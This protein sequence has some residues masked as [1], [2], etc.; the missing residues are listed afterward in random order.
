MGFSSLSLKDKTLFTL[1]AI[2]LLF[3]A[4]SEAFKNFSA[5]LLIGFFL[6]SVVSGG[7]KITKDIINIS[8]ISHLAIVLIGILVG[9]NTNESLGQVMDV[10]HIVILFLFFREANLHF[11]SYERILHFLFIGFI[12]AA[13]FGLYDLFI[14]GYRLNLRSVGSVNRSAVYIAYIFVTSLCLIQQYRGKFNNIIFYSVLILSLI[15]I[16]LGGS[17]MAIFSLAPIIIF[18]LFLLKKI[19]YK[20]IILI[21]TIIILVLSLL[22]NTFADT[23]VSSK[24]LQG[25][26]DFQRLQIWSSSFSAWSENNL[27]FGIGVGNSIFINVEDYFHSASLTSFIDNPHNVYLDMLLERG[28]LGLIT[29]LIFIFAIFFRKEKKLE[30]MKFIR[31]LIFSLLLMGLA[32]ITFRYEFAILFIVMIGAY[33]NPN[34]MK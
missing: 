10:I 22:V 30:H 34:I 1:V 31:I 19:N 9:I 2:L 16:I 11:L 14:Q 29:F 25:L 4:Y 27:W 5:Y 17:R 21:L 8:I 28:L 7:I 6:F 13:F 32:N 20:I 12:F 33:L 3:L 15:S 24:L 23:F 18:Y 26:N